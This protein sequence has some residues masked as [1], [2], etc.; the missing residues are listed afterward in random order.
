MFEYKIQLPFKIIDCV[1]CPFRREEMQHE[2]VES[3]DKLSG[4]MQIIRRDSHC[5]LRDGAPILASQ[6]VEGYN[7]QCPLKG[8]AVLLPD[9]KVV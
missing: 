2:G 3:A 5:L 7:S 9:D 4:V 8:K 6:Q 1:C